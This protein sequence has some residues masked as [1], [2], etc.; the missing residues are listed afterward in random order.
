[1]HLHCVDAFCVSFTNQSLGQV[2]P[3]PKM[4][5]ARRAASAEENFVSKEEVFVSANV[6]S[7]ALPGLCNAIFHSFYVLCVRTT[8]YFKR[9]PCHGPRIL[10]FRAPCT[11]CTRVLTVLYCMYSTQCFLRPFHL[12]SPVSK[13]N[14]E[15][16]NYR[17]IQARQNKCQ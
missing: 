15:Y 8:G 11:V 6:V 3:A 9:T 4:S 5:N 14:H 10:L 7:T 17:P 12:F 16:Q 2:C 1:M 13:V